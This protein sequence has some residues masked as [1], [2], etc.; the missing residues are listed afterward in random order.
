MTQD[1]RK[2][3]RYRVKESAF[4]VLRNHDSRLG[5][6]IDISKNGLAMKY[7]AGEDSLDN[8]LQL[9]IFLSNTE[10]YLKSV[11]FKTTSDIQFSG[12]SSVDG[13]DLRRRG[14]QF[15][16]LTKK[17]TADVELFIR[18]YTLGGI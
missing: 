8:L 4:V 18:Q 13:V 17:Q 15:G 10:F 7:I 16:K 6:V 14:G 2:Y 9:D 11:R 1:K 5:Q 3:P 12:A